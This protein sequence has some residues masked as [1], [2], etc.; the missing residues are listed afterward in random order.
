MTR[1]L[2][3]KAFLPIL[4]LSLLCFALSCKKGFDEYYNESNTKGGFL[5]DKIKANPEFSTFAKGLERANLTQFISE[6]GLYTVFAPTNEAFSKFLTNSGYS[7][8]DVVPTADLFRILSFH[9]VNN[10]W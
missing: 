7:S 2:K 6:G 1:N 3:P 4:F 10:M 5:Y 9:I 8:I